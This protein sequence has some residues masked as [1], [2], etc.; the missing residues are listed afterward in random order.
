MLYSINIIILD[1]RTN[2]LV[3][4]AVVIDLYV[5]SEDEANCNFLQET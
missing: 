3:E 1:T 2:Q 5:N 4:G